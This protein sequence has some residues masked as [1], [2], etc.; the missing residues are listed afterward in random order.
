[1]KL[2]AGILLI[3]GLAIQAFAAGV[4]G[5]HECAELLL[6][7]AEV[8]AARTILANAY[9]DGRAAGWVQQN[10]CISCHTVV[11]F[12]V[13]RSGAGA[14]SGEAFKEV[15]RLV[16][17]RINAETPLPA[18]YGGTREH[19]SYATESVLNSLI[20]SQIDTLKNV[21]RTSKITIKAFQRL[22]E[23]QN[24][25]GSWEWLDYSLQPWETHEAAPYGATLAAVAISR[26]PARAQPQFADMVRKMKAYLKASSANEH[27]SLW[28]RVSVLWANA[29]IKGVM[30]KAVVEKTLSELMAKQLPSGGFSMNHLGNWKKQGSFPE[31][32]ENTADGYASAYVLFILKQVNDHGQ[33]PESLKPRFNAVFHD[34]IN[35]LV[36]HETA[37]GTWTS[38]S[39]NSTDP[40]NRGLVEDAATG[41]ALAV[42]N[43]AH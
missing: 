12:V 37:N 34:G 11:P 42:L 43:R 20:L 10:S 41:F 18:W 14:L 22:K 2:F 36:D 7:A 25:D 31:A 28:N 35:W 32:G 13:G 39:L 33:I 27:L 30:S 19:S 6:P 3:F 38:A 5:P 1:M 26:S 40:F 29:E 21:R 23:M 4:P 9:L 15:E 16:S 24:A 8:T 17:T